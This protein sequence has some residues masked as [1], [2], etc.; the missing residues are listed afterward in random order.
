M[1]ALVAITSRA[2]PDHARCVEL[3]AL[4]EVW[5]KTYADDVERLVGVT[6]QSIRTSSGL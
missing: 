1:R 6:G 3:R 5:T 4:L 2:F